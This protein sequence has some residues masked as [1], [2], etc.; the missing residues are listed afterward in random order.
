[1]LEIATRFTRELDDRKR[2]HRFRQLRGASPANPGEVSLDGKDLINFAS[3][4]Y[5]GLSRHPLLKQR[6]IEFIERYGAGSTGSRLMSGNLDAYD[7]IE[8][9]LAQLKGTEAALIFPTGYQTNSTVLPALSGNN[10][11]LACDRLC[12]NSLLHGASAGKARWFRYKHNDVADLREKLT[13][14]CNESYD[15]LW[16]VTESVFGMDGDR[17]PVEQLR[18]VAA[19][20]KASLFF[21][22]AHA[23]GVLG[24][25]GMGVSPGEPNAISMGTFGKGLGSFGAYIAC[26]YEVRDYLINF[27]AGFIYSTALPPAVLGSIDAALDLVPAMSKERQ[28]LGDKAAS[29]RARL[30]LAGF[31]TGNSSTHIIPI[32]VGADSAALS[33]SAH[34]ELSG[35][36]APAIRTPTVAKNSAR[37]RISLTGEHTEAQLDHLI[38]SLKGWHERKN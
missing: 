20:F 17:A 25:H 15:S 37:V 14:R 38:K 35:I 13:V 6:A 11:L 36:Y 31:D 33:L 2:D 22:E 19:E 10:A 7:G 1:M 29:V 21:D 18:Q 34:L 26:S 5:L 28:L 16:I 32:I 3:N 27:A 4:D 12:H 8:R 9:K 23:T 30:Q 24:E